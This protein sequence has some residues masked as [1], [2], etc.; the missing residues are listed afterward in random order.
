MNNYNTN[1]R[2]FESILI[3]NKIKKLDIKIDIENTVISSCYE[4]ERYIGFD[5]KS[6]TKSC[7][8]SCCKMKITRKKGKVSIVMNFGSYNTKK[9]LVRVYQERYFCYICKKTTTEQLTDRLDRRSITNKV[10]DSILKELSNEESTYANVGRRY[11]FSRTYIM[12]LFD[13]YYEKEEINYETITSL[14]IDENKIIRNHKENYT[15]QLILFDPISKKIVDIKKDRKKAFVKEALLDFPKIEMVSMDLWRTYRNSVLEHDKNIKIVPDNFHVVR[16]FCWAFDRSRRKV[17]E[18]KEVSKSK[19]WKI[20]S[21]TKSKLDEEGLKILEQTFTEHDE[22]RILHEVKEKAYELFSKISLEEYKTK[23]KEL[24]EIIFNNELKEF[25]TPLNTID[26]WSEHIE[27]LY[28][29]PSISNGILERINSKIK[30]I[31][32][33]ARGFK[34]MERM[35]NIMMHKINSISIF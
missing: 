6:V 4:D 8:C 19:N 24:K 27:N 12:N 21:K 33:G 23:L 7:F 1:K 17:Y 11:G 28:K 9:V 30:Y 20:L 16:L 22:L 13:T 3:K 2:Y 34:N 5:L 32:R 15:Y 10:K 26:E 35:K 29:N 31:K 25:Y 18:S 14:C